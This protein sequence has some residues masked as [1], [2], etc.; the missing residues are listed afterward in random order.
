MSM[1]NKKAPLLAGLLLIAILACNINNPRNLS[2]PNLEL[3]IT[4]QALSISVQQTGEVL[5]PTVVEVTE[6][7]APLPSPTDTTIAPSATPQN[8]LVINS[9]LCWVGPGAK[10]EVVSS[11]NKG[12]TVEVIGRGSTAGWFIIRNPRYH[13]PCWVQADNLQLDA[14]FDINALQVYNPPP[15]PTNTPKPTPIPSETPV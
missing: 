4:A 9:S 2:Q 7:T 3:T 15:L 8:P 14:S 1:R 10:Y 13:D 5:A 11:L 6:T 12:E